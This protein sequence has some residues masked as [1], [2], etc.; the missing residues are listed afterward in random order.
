MVHQAFYH[1]SLYLHTD[2]ADGS[3]LSRLPRG[4]VPV[5][6]SPLN[7][8]RCRYSV[9]LELHVDR[10][11]V[12]ESLLDALPAIIMDDPKSLLLPVW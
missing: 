8:G 11:Q 4:A 6:I 12:L 1:S 7:S 2:A 9:K 3:L 5:L 10:E